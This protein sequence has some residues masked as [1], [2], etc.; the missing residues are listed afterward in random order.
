MLRRTAFSMLFKACAASWLPEPI[1]R[2]DFHHAVRP[3]SSCRLEIAETKSRTKKLPKPKCLLGFGST[4]KPTRVVGARL[5]APRPYEA[6]HRSH[7][8]KKVREK[9]S[10]VLGWFQPSAPE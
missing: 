10:V 6:P 8:A 4:R 7:R 1:A 5:L 3:I 9:R 2:N